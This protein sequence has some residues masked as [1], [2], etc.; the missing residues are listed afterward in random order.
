LVS[1]TA[2]ALHAAETGRLTFA[3][4]HCGERRPAAAGV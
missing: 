1:D 2:V 3:Q 4:R